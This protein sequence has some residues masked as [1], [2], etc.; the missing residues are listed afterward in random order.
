MIQHQD[1]LDHE[2]DL[3]LIQELVLERLPLSFQ[4]VEC[5]AVRRL[6]PCPCQA[7]SSRMTR[8][9]GAGHGCRN[10]ALCLDPPAWLG[11]PAES[12]CA[13][14]PTARAGC[15]FDRGPLP[16]QDQIISVSGAGEVVVYEDKTEAGQWLTWEPVANYKGSP[17]VHF[18][19]TLYH[20]ENVDISIVSYSLSD[21][22]TVARP[23]DI[24]S[25]VGLGGMIQ[26]GGQLWTWNAW[27]TLAVQWRPQTYT[28]GV[29]RFVAESN[30]CQV[31]TTEERV[32]LRWWRHF[33]GGAG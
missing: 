10:L 14:R 12:S 23:G 33:V 4:G 18:V 16:R 25:F 28:V 8:G 20:N 2:H 3:W 6:P 32:S 27:T 5:H 11:Q 13:R 29:W 19:D 15:W 9:T 24:P 7:S 26:C 17:V 31:V 30:K 22:T 1:Y 21:Q